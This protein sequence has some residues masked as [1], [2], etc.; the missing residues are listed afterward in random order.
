MKEFSL[1]ILILEGLVI[2]AVFLFLVRKSLAKQHALLDPQ[3][4]KRN[5][6]IKKGFRYQQ[7]IFPYEM[8]EVHVYFTPGGKKSPPYTHVTTKMVP[9]RPYTITL[10]KEIEVFSRI[11]EVFGIKDIQLNNPVFDEAF[12]V[13]GSDESVVHAFFSSGIQNKLL[14]FKDKRPAFLIYKNKF[15]FSVP[16]IPNDDTDLDNIIDTG[17]ILL[18]RVNE[19]S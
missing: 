5:G 12:V 10:Y 15:S 8:F 16:G 11:A 2:A 13:K 9:L 14:L 19:V 3:V 18:S 4:I 7:L 6:R 17:L 1:S